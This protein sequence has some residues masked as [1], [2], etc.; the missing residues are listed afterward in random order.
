MT[1]ELDESDR[2]MI[3]LSLA[4]CSLLRPGWNYAAGEIAKKLGDL[5]LKMYEDFRK[6]NSD[7]VKPTPI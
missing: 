7:V 1:T 2:Q 4:L 5:D 3:I 6:Y